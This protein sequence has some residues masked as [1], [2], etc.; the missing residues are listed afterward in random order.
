MCGVSARKRRL[1][2]EIYIV[3]AFGSCAAPERTTRLVGGHHSL[4]YRGRVR[5]DIYLQRAATHSLDNTNT[6]L[7]RQIIRIIIQNC[8]SVSR[9]G[10]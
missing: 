4:G 2:K 9:I 10:K 7:P 1:F 5:T 3:I 6:L 8:A